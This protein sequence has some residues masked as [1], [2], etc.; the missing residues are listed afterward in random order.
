MATDDNVV[1]LKHLS[2]LASS[3]AAEIATLSG[4]SSGGSSSAS[5]PNNADFALYVP[6]STS[7]IVTGK[8]PPQLS[9][10][11]WSYAGDI[12][13]S[14]NSAKV[15]SAPVIYN[16]D[17]TLSTDTGTISNGV[18][19][20]HDTD[21]IF[22]GVISAAPGNEYAASSL[23]FNHDLDPVTVSSDANINA[24]IQTVGADFVPAVDNAAD[25]AAHAD[26]NIQFFDNRIKKIL[27]GGKDYV[28]ETCNSFLNGTTT[29]TTVVSDNRVYLQSSTNGT[30]VATSVYTTISTISTD[31]TF[32]KV[33][34]RTGVVLFTTKRKNGDYEYPGE[35]TIQAVYVINS[36]AYN[37]ITL[38][39][40]NPSIVATANS[41]IASC[42]GYQVI[43]A[44]NSPKSNS[45]FFLSKSID[46]D[47]TYETKTQCRAVRT[48]LVNENY[49]TSDTVKRINNSSTNS[50]T[51]FGAQKVY[52]GAHANYFDF[53]KAFAP[54]IEFNGE[55]VSISKGS[56]PKDIPILLYD[57]VRSDSSGNDSAGSAFAYFGI[58]NDG[59]LSCCTLTSIATADTVFADVNYS[60]GD[61]IT[62]KPWVEDDGS[63]IL[64]L[65][66]TKKY[67]NQYIITYKEGSYTKSN[68]LNN[69][70]D[71]W[72]VE[73][74]ASPKF[75]KTTKKIT[76]VIDDIV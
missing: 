64:G 53:A 29:V 4:G 47:K 28:A 25:F 33:G 35:A 16:G 49:S 48:Q 27:D 45:I 62:I 63:V 13:N 9:I 17:G 71:V 70:F 68:W 60:A 73:N 43:T 58:E 44:L 76:D 54:V 40:H 55:A 52:T 46:K 38:A 74:T 69:A 34:E 23:Y 65:Y 57:S 3:I 22:E 36:K 15:Y 12:F 21:G 32:Y 41:S 19:T 75:T 1:R 31:S 37:Y 14:G 2:S 66:P 20:V 7:I 56:T 24:A 50:A 11:S 8:Q 6:N 61:T 18:L 26:N 51:I 67:N 42:E 39:A 59:N 10:G 30:S 72:I 5:A